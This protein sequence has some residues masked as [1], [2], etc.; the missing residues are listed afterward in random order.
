ML[1]GSGFSTGVPDSRREVIGGLRRVRGRQDG[2][3]AELAGPFGDELGSGGELS[4][5]FVTL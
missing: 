3:G 1:S 5:G 2:C 4:F